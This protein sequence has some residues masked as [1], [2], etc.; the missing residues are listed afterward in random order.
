MLPLK[1]VL[2]HHNVSQAWLAREVGVSPATI[3]Q[4]V[5]QDQWPKRP[6]SNTL[7][8]LIIDALA[9]QKIVLENSDEFFKPLPQPARV[10]AAMT[11]K[12]T[13]EVQTMLLRKQSLSPQAR[14]HFS[15]LRDPF[16][17]DVQEAD[18]VFMTPDIRH[19][20]EYL[21]TTAK[22]GGFIA[23]VGESGAGKSTLRK[24][25]EERIHGED[26]QI[27]VM[28]PYVLGM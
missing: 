10:E 1:Q 26:A 4:L 8:G 3:A 18:D 15:L 22:F 17:N 24:D 19:V 14:K 27:L 25:L 5:N 7:K 23:I 12:L 11:S 16:S 9:Q 20:R 13:E 6:D 21:W 28:S 2:Q